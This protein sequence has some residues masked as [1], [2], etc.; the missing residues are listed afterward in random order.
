MIFQE[1][2][3]EVMEQEQ[4]KTRKQLGDDDDSRTGSEGLN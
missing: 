4:E 1:D 3:S 2:Q